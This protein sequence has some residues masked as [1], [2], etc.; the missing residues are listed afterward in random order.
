MYNQ[1]IN[2]T[3]GNQEV[4]FN[5]IL[6][7][8]GDTVRENTNGTKFRLCNIK[9]DDVNGKPQTILASVYEK[10]FEK[11]LKVG[12]QYLCTAQKETATGRVYIHV[13]ALPG[14]AIANADMFSFEP[15]IEKVATPAATVGA[16]PV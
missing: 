2:K 16:I 14:G 1:R 10:N 15:V 9:F 4:D 12:D 6:L 11:G 8:I 5:G 7:S 13:S 3:T